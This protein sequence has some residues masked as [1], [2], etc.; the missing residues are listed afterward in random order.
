VRGRMG[1]GPNQVG[2]SRLHI[3]E[4]VEASLKRLGTDYIDL[5]QIHRTD[6]YT[7]IE[8]TLRALDDLVR[9]GKVRYIGCSN[10]P[11]WQLMKA[12]GISQARGLERFQCTQSYYSL[13]GRE[14]EHDVIPLLEDQRLGLLVWSPLAGGFLSGKF[15]RKTKGEGRRKTFD[16][17]PVDKERGFDVVDVLMRIA[18]GHG[19]SAARVALAWVLANEA[20]TSVIIGARNLK[21]LDD[22]IAAVDL[23]LSPE[24]LKAL[25]EVSRL[26][27]AYPAWM[28]TLGSDRRPGEV[29]RL[30]T[31]QAA[32]ARPGDAKQAKKAKPARAAKKKAAKRR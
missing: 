12:L 24:D 22:N 19:V 16:F 14:L 4:G 13:V 2:L 8:A 3:M 23:E 18:K 6:P 29:R 30:Q 31:A 21:Q 26:P 25:D 7:D 10:L 20:V 28:D 5:Y 15:T 17:P 11:A 27:P 9:Q 32:A 1:M